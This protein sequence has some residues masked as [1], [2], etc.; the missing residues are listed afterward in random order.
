MTGTA[1]HPLSS[2]GASRQWDGTR[3][4]G[5]DQY[6][7]WTLE[8]SDPRLSGALLSV[9]DLIFYEDLGVYVADGHS[10]LETAEGRWSGEFTF[11]GGEALANVAIV[12]LTAKARTR[13]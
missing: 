10:K 11:V 1:G 6:E 7:V 12:S 8:A 5:I 2:A 9:F 4:V 3:V 13:A